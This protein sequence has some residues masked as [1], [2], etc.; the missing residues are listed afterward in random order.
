M[1]FSFTKIHKATHTQ[2]RVYAMPP[3]Y[4]MRHIGCIKFYGLMPYWAKCTYV[5]SV[6]WRSTIDCLYYTCTILLF[7]AE[8]C[9]DILYI[10]LLTHKK[11][12]LPLCYCHAALH[13][14]GSRWKNSNNLMLTFDGL[15]C[16]FFSHTHSSFPL[17]LAHWRDQSWEAIK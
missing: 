14:I 10:W 1:F 4:F 5:S 11:N 2:L 8:C 3:R 17:Y 6:V 7:L 13:K 12:T 15:L 16:F 9:V